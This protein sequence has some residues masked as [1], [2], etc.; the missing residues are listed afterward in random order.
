M[1]IFDKFNNQDLG[2]EEAFE[3]LCCQL[4]ET[5][6]MRAMGFDNTWAYRDIRGD[7]GDGGI[8]AY[9]FNTEN[10][11]YIGIQAKWFKK[12]ISQAQYGQI[13]HSIDTAIGLRPSLTK[14][15]VCIPHNLTS[16]RNSKNETVSLGEEGTWKMFAE[17]IAQAYPDLELVCGMSISSA[18]SCRSPRTRA[19]SVSGS[20]G[21]R[22][23]LME[24]ASRYGVR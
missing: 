21:L 18:I 12:T 22:S 19:A 3:E 5:W 7:G 9:W 23:I 4:F 14:Y 10:S 17:S 15:I 6:G 20:R 2:D 1:G 11:E 13:R 16:L 24:C 8:E